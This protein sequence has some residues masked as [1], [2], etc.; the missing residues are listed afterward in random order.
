MLPDTSGAVEF[1]PLSLAMNGYK[2]ALICRFKTK[3]LKEELIKRA[4]KFDVILIDANEPKVLFRALRAIKNGRMLITE[5]DE[6]SEWRPHPDKRISVFGHTVPTGQDTG[7]FIPPSQSA[8]TYGTH[9]ARKRGLYFMY[10]LPCRWWQ[11]CIFGCQGMETSLRTI[12]SAIPNSGINGKM[13]QQRCMNTLSW[14]TRK[15][16]K[17]LHQ[18]LLSALFYLPIIH[19]GSGLKG[20]GFYSYI[21][22]NQN[23]QINGSDFQWT[24][25]T[26][27]RLA[28]L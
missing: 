18:Y 4:K 26:R 25:E 11:R 16:P 21:L 6:F 23:S 14:T 1:L 22:S 28:K 5:C 12:Y 3:K 2:I 8:G 17:K 15:I 10:R 27:E 7:L 20:S 24:S 9:E 13:L 19:K